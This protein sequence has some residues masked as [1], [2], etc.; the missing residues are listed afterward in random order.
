[1]VIQNIQKAVYLGKFCADEARVA[2]ALD[3]ADNPAGDVVGAHPRLTA[4]KRFFRVQGVLQVRVFFI[5][6]ANKI[7]E[8]HRRNL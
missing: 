1:M 7:S 3:V 2:V 8:K 6:I 5:N 4:H